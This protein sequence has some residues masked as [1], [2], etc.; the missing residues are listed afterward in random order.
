MKQTVYIYLFEGYSDWE[1][2]F[3]LPELRKLNQFK[4]EFV[5][6]CRQKVVSMGGLEVTPTKS[7][8]DIAWNR[9]AAFI[10]PG[11]HLWESNRRTKT[12]LFSYLNQVVE[13]QCV[14]ASICSATLLL[15]S[16]G[17]LDNKLHTSNSLEYLQEQASM[18]KG[19][20]LYI[21]QPVVF[22]DGVITANG[23]SPIEF[24]KEILL[25]LNVDKYY[26]EQWYQL[27]KHG[28]W[29]EAS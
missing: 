24:T 26:V 19:E 16:V 1:I 4:I 27:F 29:S 17:L 10:I 7:L 15:A 28:V 8:R 14:I 6:D 5:S 12:K 23:I 22:D 20:L 25:V 3:L 21:D 2:S 13:S 18:Y 11:G 9:V